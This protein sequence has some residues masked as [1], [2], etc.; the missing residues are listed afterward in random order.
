[1][2]DSLKRISLMVKEEQYQKLA[3][4]GL[5]V[6]G[7]IRDLVDDYLSDYKITLGVTEETRNLYDTIVSN[8]GSCDQDIE[9]YFRD[10]LKVMLRD[11]IKYMQELERKV[12]ND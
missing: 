4:K 11:K 5:N 12:F 9:G 10:S 8:T 7:L 1:M 2:G 6:S 3:D